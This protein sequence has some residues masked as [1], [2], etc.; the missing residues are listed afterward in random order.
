[1]ALDNQLETHG[2]EKQ[3]ALPV[4][5]ERKRS[6][7][8]WFFSLFP[9]PCEARNLVKEIHSQGSRTDSTQE[10]IEEM[11]KSRNEYED[12]VTVMEL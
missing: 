2:G 12:F 11:N 7:Q 3:I 1:V 8:S 5:R 10:C 9:P 4:E 6:G